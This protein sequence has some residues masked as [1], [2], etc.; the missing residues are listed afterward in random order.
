MN[1][2]LKGVRE[3]FNLPILLV[4]VPTV[5]LGFLAGGSTNILLLLDSSVL[6]V[7]LSIS[8]NVI[9]NYADWDIDVMN[10]KRNIMHETWL[11]NELLVFYLILLVVLLVIA[12]MSHA[13][14]YLW[15]TVALLV[16]L[17]ICYSITIRLKN[18]AP[19]NYIAIA[20]AYGFLSFYMGFFTSSFSSSKF[21]LWIPVPLFLFAMDLGY[22]ITKDYS[23]VIGDKAYGKKTLPLAIGKSGSLKAQAVI[24][25]SAYVFLLLLI[26]F[27]K[28]SY[29]FSVLF[30]SYVFALYILWQTR[31]TD[32]NKLLR[33][34][35]LEAQLNGL[36][37]RFI[38]IMI[39][40]LALAG[41]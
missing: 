1:N 6:I 7:L 18:T 26:I 21:W 8:A 22:S 29:A 24:I 34:A 19:L 30:L 37:A 36:L 5:A 31:S 4:V 10:K 39:L 41:I 38:M 23:D 33:N 2:R 15:I 14:V 13:S 35:H 11:R 16:L 40:L 25:T 9:N 28:L 17:G 32:N 12:F 27:G 20:G 3:A